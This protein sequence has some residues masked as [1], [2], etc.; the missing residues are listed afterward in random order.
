MAILVEIVSSRE[1]RVFQRGK[2]DCRLEGTVFA[3]TKQI[4]LIRDVIDHH[5]IGLLIFVEVSR[6]EATREEGNRV[7]NSSSLVREVRRGQVR[8]VRCRCEETERAVLEFRRIPRQSIDRC[9]VD[10]SIA[11]KITGLDRLG[12]AAHGE[13][14]WRK[15]PSAV[16]YKIVTLSDCRLATARSRS[17]SRSK[18]AVSQGTGGLTPRGEGAANDGSNDLVKWVIR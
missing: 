16:A 18:S 8:A 13:V 2:T 6:D 11:V 10:P 4:E 9:Q 1:L 12:K 3:A 14:F 5:E 15:R 7:A 17:P